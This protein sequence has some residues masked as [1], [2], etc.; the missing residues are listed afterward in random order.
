MAEAI[1][2]VPCP[3]CRNVSDSA[4]PGGTV[5]TCPRCG[6]TYV[7]RICAACGMVSHVDVRHPSRDPWHCVWCLAANTG[8]THKDPAAATIADLAAD[9]ANHRLTFGGGPESAVKAK[10]PVLIVTT[11]DIPGYRITKVHGD[12]FGRA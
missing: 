5:W 10:Q 1:A 3:N 8:F 7:L 4:H 9:V 11:N 6:S 2:H 12:V